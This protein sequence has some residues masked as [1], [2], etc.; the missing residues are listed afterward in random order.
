MPEREKLRE[1]ARREGRF[2]DDFLERSPY[3]DWRADN[4]AGFELE[5]GVLRMY[6]GPTE[7][8]YYSNAEISDGLFDDLPWSFKTMEVKARLRGMH[9]G[10]AGWGFWNHSM[11]LELCMPIWFIYLRAR[12]PYPLQ[13][14]FAQVGRT[15]QPIVVFGSGG[16][17]AAAY[18]LSRL[19]ERLVGVRVVSPRPSMPDL[20]LG[21]WHVY[22]V[23]WGETVRFS[24]DGKRVA[25]IP[26]RG[27]REAR[28]RADVWIDNAVYEARRGDAGAVYRHVTQEVRER[29]YLELDYVAIY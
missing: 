21:G 18:L 22:R 23:E 2:R 9:Y 14:F 17:L 10:S 11:A 29:A 26:F 27:S 16:K 12:G 13:G 28:A 8:L 1:K 15:F 19:S 20:D 25:E 24:V 3:W 4:Y 6:V 5:S 7:A